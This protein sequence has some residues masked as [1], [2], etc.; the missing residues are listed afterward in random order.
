M[1]MNNMNIAYDVNMPFKVLFDHIEDG[2]DHF[3]YLVRLDIAAGTKTL[4][5]I[6]IHCKRTHASN[7]TK[8]LVHKTTHN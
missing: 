3:C 7:P 1:N 2:M 8:S 6:R 5:K 4:T